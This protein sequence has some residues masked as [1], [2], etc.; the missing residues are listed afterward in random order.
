MDGPVILDEIQYIPELY[1]PIKK[2][3]DETRL[4][5]TDPQKVNGLFL[6]TGSTNVMAL[7]ELS[8]ALVGRVSIL[9]L[10]PF[11]AGEAEK[12]PEGFIEA[13]FSKIQ[14]AIP[15]KV[16]DRKMQTWLQLA[17]FPDLAFPAKNLGRW[18]NDYIQTLIQRD[19]KAVGEIEKQE[20]M[21]RLLQMLAGRAAQLVNETN[22]SQDIGLTRVTYRRYQALLEQLFLID[23]LPAWNDNII[24]RMAK[25]PKIFFNDTMLL[26]HLLGVDVEEIDPL[27]D[28]EYGHILENFVYTELVKQ[29]SRREGYKLFHFRTSDGKEIDFI[30]E[31]QDRKL[32]AVEVKSRKTIKADDFKPLELLRGSLGDRFANG[33]ILYDGADVISFGDRITAVPLEAL[34]FAVGNEQYNLGLK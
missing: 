24:K 11:S 26:C 27:K 32:A 15:K 29:I 3:I 25:S 17:T 6:L 5:E 34:W 22:I 8:K 33:I 30:I 31:R 9:T 13:A 18:A 12:F 23:F 20:E 16:A 2:K 4:K 21:Y 28:R 10:F 19:V 7:P 14:F 1:L